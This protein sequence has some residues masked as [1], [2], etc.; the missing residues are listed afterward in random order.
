MKRSFINNVLFR[1]VTPAIYGVIVYIL[2][3]LIFDSIKQLLQNFFSFEVFFCILITYIAFE[4]MRVI[5]NIFEKRFVGI[6][7]L[8]LRIALQL[9]ANALGVFVTTS[10]ILLLYYKYLIGFSEFNTELIVFNTIYIFTCIFYNILYFSIVFLNRTN[11]AKIKH[12]SILKQS[13]VNELEEYKSK[14]NPD[15]LYSS[16]ETM[17]ALIRKDPSKAS[18]FIQNLSDVY[19]YIVSSKRNEPVQLQKELEISEKLIRILNAKYQNSISLVNEVSDPNSNGKLI[20]GTL[21]IVIEELIHNNLVS[22]IQPLL[23]HCRIKENF[24]IIECH[25]IK[26]LAKIKADFDELDNLK[27]VY[28]QFSENTITINENNQTNLVSIPLLGYV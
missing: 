6:P 15:L 24:L 10:I 4:L 16:L 12:E 1:I 2:I 26:R 5:T 23:L 22:E 21:H 28:L 27:K 7:Q 18:D 11:E 19:R 17:I 14:I 3:L 20:P 9:A 25:T 8:Y 13:I